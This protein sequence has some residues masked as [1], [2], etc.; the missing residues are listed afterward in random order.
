MFESPCGWFLSFTSKIEAHPQASFLK[1]FDENLSEIRNQLVSCFLK[2][3]CNRFLSHC[4]AKVCDFFFQYD[5]PREGKGEGKPFWVLAIIFQTTQKVK[6][7]FQ[8]ECDLIRLKR[9]F[10]FYLVCSLYSY[11]P[12][13]QFYKTR[14]H[15]YSDDGTFR[16]EDD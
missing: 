15:F 7:D 9:L 5:K 16:I 6:Q 13:D 11:R 10:S 1:S 3:H 4:S 14:I 2:D 12:F 8:S